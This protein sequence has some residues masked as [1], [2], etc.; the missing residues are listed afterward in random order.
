MRRS[1]KWKR[2]GKT[3]TKSVKEYRVRGEKQL[4]H[5]FSSLP[6]LSS[7]VGD[8]NTTRKKKQ[9]KESVN[10][11]KG[12][13]PLKNFPFC[14]VLCCAIEGKFCAREQ[15]LGEE[16]SGGKEKRSVKNRSHAHTKNTELNATRYQ[17]TEY[18]TGP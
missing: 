18:R 12:K 3:E 11:L 17:L 6:F 2:G 8:T 4:Q 9:K 10:S 13:Q 7:S 15:K 1:E 5:F 14:V 16:K